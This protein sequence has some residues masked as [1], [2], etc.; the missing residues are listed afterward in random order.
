MKKI[1]AALAAAL[2][3]A[4]AAF[5]QETSVKYPVETSGPRAVGL[6]LGYG[7]N[8]SY[9]HAISRDNMISADLGLPGFNSWSLSATYDWINPFGTEIPWTSAK[10][11]WNWYL[12]AGV[13]GGTSFAS[14]I[15]STGVSV[16]NTSGFFG[17]VGNLGLEYNFWFP[18]QLSVDW[19]PTFGVGLNTTR[20]QVPESVKTSTSAGFYGAGLVAGAFS[21][22]VRYLF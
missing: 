21:I 9:Q 4:G 18:L 6:R 14:S 12:G 22:G 19:R 5:A 11:S 1:F 13:G 8:I 16:K 10:G 7:I 15:S 2:L 3:L 17:L 20:T